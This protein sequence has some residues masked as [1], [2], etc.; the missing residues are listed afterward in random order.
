M[1][2]NDEE[3]FKTHDTFCQFLK[4]L[5]LNYTVVPKDVADI[6]ECVN[7]VLAVHLQAR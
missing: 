7:P 6:D 4:T 1:P 2:L 3:W 5:G